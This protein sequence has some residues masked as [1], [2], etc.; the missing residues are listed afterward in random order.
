M[1]TEM[2]MLSGRRVTLMTLTLTATSLRHVSA[3]YQ[4]EIPV[5]TPAGA[6]ITAVIMTLVVVT[7]LSYFYQSLKEQA[8]GHA[9][10]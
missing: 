9:G 1:I 6:A 10:Q 3:G 5:D 7:V 2:L 8:S 4:I